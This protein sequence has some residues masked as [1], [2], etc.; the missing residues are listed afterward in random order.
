MCLSIALGF[1]VDD[2]VI[3][4]MKIIT[5]MWRFLFFSSGT[6]CTARYPTPL[7]LRSPASPRRLRPSLSLGACLP[8]ADAA[9]AAAA[10]G[11]VDNAHRGQKVTVHCTGYGKN[12]DL[13]KKFWST[14]DP[15]QVLFFLSQ[16]NYLSIFI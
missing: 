9:S 4:M 1:S 16:S 6:C 5:L 8:A 7:F 13:S 12:R 14:K 2:D 10:A 15:G 11:V 3:R